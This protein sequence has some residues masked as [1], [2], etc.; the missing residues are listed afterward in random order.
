MPVE[1]GATLPDVSMIPAVPA[2]QKLAL[3]IPT[4]REAGSL[5][6]LLP[7]VRRVLDSCGVQYEILIVDD[8]SQDGTEELIADLTAEDPRVRLLV[9]RGERG[10]SGAIVHGWQRTH[11][12]LLG[13]MDADLQHPPELLPELISRA[14]AGA[15]VVIGSRYVKGGRVG[16]WNP[17]RKLISAAAV[18][19]TWPIQRSWLRAKDPMSGFFLVRRS[20]VQHVLFQPTGFKLLLEILV[21]GDIRSVCEVP[22]S[23]GRRS[24]GTSKACAKVA[25]EYLHL[26]VKLYGARWSRPAVVDATASEVAGD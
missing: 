14:L 19:V 26:L 5:R 24:A 2:A 23:F 11:A 4:L 8:D 20:C 6:T 7:Q 21:R 25:W 17:I 22:F 3:I 12:E 9:R 13:V 16:E 18:W 1:S 15:D 10:L